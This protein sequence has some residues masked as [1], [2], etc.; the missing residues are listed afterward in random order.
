MW[1]PHILRNNLRQPPRACSGRSGLFNAWPIECVKF[2]FTQYGF[3]NARGRG[4]C[5]VH[6]INNG[7]RIVP[8]EA[9]DRATLIL[10]REDHFDQ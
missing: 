8:Q 5:L 3:A 10:T 4:T 9:A 2:Q 7:L 1:R 6:H